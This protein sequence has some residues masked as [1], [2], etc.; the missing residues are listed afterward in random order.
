MLSLRDVPCTIV[1]VCI[2]VRDRTKKTPNMVRTRADKRKRANEVGGTRSQALDDA[3]GMRS[4]CINHPKGSGFQ[5]VKSA[6]V[7]LYLGGTLGGYR[8][9][10]PEDLDSP[11]NLREAGILARV[12]CK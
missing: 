7:L 9:E 5:H 2:D 4:H 3:N 10:C 1:I 6:T 11:D 12:H 8:P